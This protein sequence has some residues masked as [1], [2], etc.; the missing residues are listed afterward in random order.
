MRDATPA[1]SK[2]QNSL[3]RQGCEGLGKEGPRVQ[4]GACRFLEAGGGWGGGTPKNSG[5]LRRERKN[6]LTSAAIGAI[7][8][9][10]TI[11]DLVHVW[12]PG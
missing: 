7:Y 6:S 1:N 11:Y 3:V 10:N 8:S 12:A 5:K 4:A 2:R 9:F